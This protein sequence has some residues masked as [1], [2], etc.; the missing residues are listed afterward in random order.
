MYPAKSGVVRNGETTPVDEDNEEEEKVYHPV[1]PFQHQH[2]LKYEDARPEV[3]QLAPNRVPAS[4]ENLHVG[5][6]VARKIKPN[7]LGHV[8]SII[9]K[10]GFSRL[11]SGVWVR[12]AGKN[13]S[14]LY[15][16]DDLYI[17]YLN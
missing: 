17:I 6:V 1:V 3:P 2:T 13:S 11:I 9:F 12:F 10:F 7:S 16:I 14:L 15:S 8:T 5:S 4:N